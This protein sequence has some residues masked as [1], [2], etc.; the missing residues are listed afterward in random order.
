MDQVEKR[1]A[2]SYEGLQSHL[3]QV[4]FVMN[5]QV[6][7]VLE[8]GTRFSLVSSVIG[9]HCNLTTLDFKKEFYPDLIIDISDLKQF[10]TLKDADYDLILLCEVLEHIPY[11]KM[12]GIFKLLK[13]KTRKYVIISVPDQSSYINITFFGYGI[14]NKISKVLKKLFNLFS[15]KIGN[16]I[17]KLDYKFRKSKRKFI[18]R[19]FEVDW[20][21][22]QW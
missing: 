9:S 5:L 18:M 8:I 10:D 4:Y 13:N 6:N 20:H 1:V 19:K 22:H 14:G 11:E 17:S 3:M 2:F 15:A 21:T 7:D 12:D 16:L